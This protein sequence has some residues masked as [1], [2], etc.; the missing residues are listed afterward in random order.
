MNGKLDIKQLRVGS[1]I[2]IIGVADVQIES[3][4]DINQL[5]YWDSVAVT[6][7]NYWTGIKLTIDVLIKN[8][9][10][11]INGYYVLD[12]KS[13]GMPNRVVITTDFRFWF[14]S[15]DSIKLHYFHEL[16]NLMYLF[17][18]IEITN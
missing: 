7:G 18:N 17:Y 16:Q 13:D 2:H 4:D 9:F 10:K 3:G 1:W 14:S 6:K 15:N 5:L 12:I 11:Y 8:N